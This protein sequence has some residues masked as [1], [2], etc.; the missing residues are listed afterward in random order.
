MSS[1]RQLSENARRAYLLALATWMDKRDMRDLHEEL[2]DASRRGDE[3][4]RQGYVAAIEYLSDGSLQMDVERVN[5]HVERVIMREFVHAMLPSRSL[6][7]SAQHVPLVRISLCFDA[8]WMKAR[9]EI[10]LDVG[11]ADILRAFAPLDREHD[12]GMPSIDLMEELRRQKEARVKYTEH[13]THEIMR[14][15]RRMVKSG[16][17]L[18]GVYPENIKW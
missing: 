18:K 12:G 2:A 15:L 3:E 5:R 16:D 7:P 17:P 1:E 6:H 8:P 9:Q 13:L 11:L 14:A 4:T 10:N